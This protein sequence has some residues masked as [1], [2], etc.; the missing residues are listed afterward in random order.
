M[1]V[2][3]KMAETKATVEKLNDGNY[4]VWKFKMRLL[5]TK[6]KLL[7]VVTDPKPEL[8][9]ASWNSNDEKA[10]AL[11]GLALEDT[12]LIHVMTKL[13]AKEMWDALKDY[14]ERASLSSIIHVVRQ[15][16]TIRM[17]ENGNMAEHLKEMA[18]LR[19][20]L[21]ALGEEVKDNWFMA[22]MLSSLPRSYDGLIV[23][24]ESRPD[25]DLTVDFVKGKLLDEGRR[26]VESE[27]HSGEK[28]LVMNTAKSNNANKSNVK[29][30]V[31]HYCKKEGHYR[32][33]CHKFAQ[34]KRDQKKPDNQKANVAVSSNSGFEVCLAASRVQR[35]DLWYLDSGA[36]A[37]MTSDASLLDSV[38]TSK[39]TVVCLADGKSVK[40]LGTG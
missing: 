15:L 37:H 36:T 27:C 29:K 20:R 14:H 22:L 21:T 32:R 17:P 30:G 3:N 33:D 40:S 24:L 19:L 7:K 12:Q 5:L 31:C 18:A 8:A 10:Q 11:I 9:D 6:E 23:A 34:D 38:D 28:A 26:R 25:A 13:T 35:S 16:I 1:L 2:K 39:A 4:A